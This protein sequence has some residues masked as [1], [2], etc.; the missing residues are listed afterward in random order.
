MLANEHRDNYIQILGKGAYVMEMA[1]A[2]MSMNMAA[3]KTQDELSIALLKKSMDSSEA[4]ME[5]ITD[6]LDNIPSPDG[7]G[8]LL[9]VHA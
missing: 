5:L 6:M 8:L 4:S 9:D 2:Q 7:R 1:I 3:A